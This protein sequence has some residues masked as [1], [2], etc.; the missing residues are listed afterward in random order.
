MLTVRTSL[1]VDT[2]RIPGRTAQILSLNINKLVWPASNVFW[3]PRAVTLVPDNRWRQ[4]LIGTML[5]H[6]PRNSALLATNPRE[7]PARIKEEIKHLA[8]SGIGTDNQKLP[9]QVFLVGDLD[10]R[11]N[12]TV[13]KEGFSTL[14]F[15][16]DDDYQLAADVAQFAVR[17]MPKKPPLVLLPFAD[18]LDSQAVAG[19]TAHSGAPILFVNRDNIPTAT[20]KALK[21]INPPAIYLIGQDNSLNPYLSDKVATILPDTPIKRITGKSVAELSVNLAE[22]YDPE[23]QFGWGRNMPAGDVLTFIPSNYQYAGIFA[24]LLS[25]LATHA[26]IIILPSHDR[27][28]D[29]VKEYLDRINPPMNMPPRPPFMRGWIVGNSDGISDRQQIELES[30]LIKEAGDWPPHM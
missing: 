2:V 9:A 20:Q 23:Y 14:V 4:A 25:H 22:Y 29:T 24:S 8:P 15:K 10:S 11:V 30:L 16:A 21:M 7:L 3:K 27:I 13:R 18:Y 6:F 1:T 28:P 26:P 12:K 17:E 5:V 19:L